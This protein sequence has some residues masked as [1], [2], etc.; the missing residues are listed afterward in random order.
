MIYDLMT[1]YTTQEVWMYLL[2]FGTESLKIFKECPHVGE[3]IFANNG[4]KLSRFF[5]RI[6]EIVKERKEILSEYNGEY[7]FFLKT[8]GK[9]MPLITII[10]NGYESFVE[11]YDDLFDDTLLTLTRE[12]S[13][14]GVVFIMTTVASNDLRYRMGQNFKQKIALTL[15]DSG[16]YSNIYD[17]LGNRKPAQ[18]FG[19][20]L[21]NLGETIYEFQTAK[22]CEP[23]EYN[24][25][26]KS[27]IEKIKKVNIITA[28]KVPVL[29]SVVKREDFNIGL[30]DLNNIPIG[31]RK[32]DIKPELYDFKNNF[33]TIIAAK[34]IEEAIQFASNIWQEISSLQQ[35]E[36]ILLDPERKILSGKNDLKENY[37]KLV[38]KIKSKETNHNVCFILGLDRWINFLEQEVNQNKEREDD[39]EEEEG[40]E[41]V[42]KLETILKQSE[43]K[44][45]FSFIIVDAASK[46]KEHNYDSWYSENV[47]EN[48]IIWVGN[49]IEDQYLIDVNAPR[50]EIID[51]CGCS[52]GYINKKDKT[53]LLKLLEMKE[54]REEDE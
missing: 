12:G 30:E 34:N 31:L 18:R 11:H 46:M 9:S 16:D 25:F 42:E 4:E 53:I 19:R 38:K 43:K 6:K 14:T 15:N 2:D 7:N 1:T 22:S 48:N 35:I 21:V 5:S 24:V 33:I 39:E 32:R 50:K 10:I 8:S 52:F 36:T 28:E 27:E 51:N 40:L 29:P 26:I 17:T 41:G 37:E 23:E 3:V 54:K 49:G 20:G 45:N 44:K 47:M 13:K